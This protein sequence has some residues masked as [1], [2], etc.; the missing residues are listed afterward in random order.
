MFFFP[1]ASISKFVILFLSIRSKAPGGWSIFLV[2][3]FFFSSR[4]SGESG[5]EDLSLGGC[6]DVSARFRLM[7]TT[8]LGKVDGLLSCPWIAVYELE[9]S[10][11]RGRDA[12][13]HGFRR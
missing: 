1:T 8:E 10:L 7:T 6:L 12:S 5:S 4:W 9:L 13:R 3:F 2:I 11:P